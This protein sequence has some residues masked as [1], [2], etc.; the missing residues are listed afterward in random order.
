MST[1]MF[2][3]GPTVS[4]ANKYSPL[5]RKIIALQGNMTETELG[6]R[7]VLSRNQLYNIKRGKTGTSP[8]TIARMVQVFGLIKR[9]DIVELYNLAGFTAPATAPVELHYELT[10]EE[11]QEIISSFEGIP[12]SLRPR[13]KRVLDAFLYAIPNDDDNL[14]TYGKRPGEE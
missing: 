5:G 13:A 14:R 10:E 2:E 11:K 7:L 4:D 9:A 12:P 6:E 3:E 1:A 8:E